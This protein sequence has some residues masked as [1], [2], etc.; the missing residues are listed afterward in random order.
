[1]SLLFESIRIENGIIYHLELH[2]KRIERS[3]IKLGSSNPIDLKQFNPTLDIP[4]K[5]IH[6]LRISYDLMG[7]Q[8]HQIIPYILRTVKSVEL[9]ECNEIVYDLKFEDRLLINQL[10]K[11]SKADEIIIVKNGMITD[12]S[13]SNIL[14]SSNDQW[15]T[16]DTPLLEGTARAHLI[17][18]GAIRS[19]PI[20]LKDL[21]HFDSFC[22]VNALNPFETTQKHPIELLLNN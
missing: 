17:E 10:T 14:F 9:M 1:M 16:P 19:I 22:F 13:I 2:Q 8:E 12:A 11:N 21:K 4:E 5:G 20:S 18:T 6:K 3:L 7:I 15:F